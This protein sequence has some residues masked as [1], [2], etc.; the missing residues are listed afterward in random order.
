MWPLFAILVACWWGWL[1]YCWFVQAKRPLAEAVVLIEAAGASFPWRRTSLKNAADVANDA[2]LTSKELSTM[3][4]A[5][6][7]PA[8]SGKRDD[9]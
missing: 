2:R 6:E 9:I 4:A 8:R 5:Q 1:A 7:S 3:R